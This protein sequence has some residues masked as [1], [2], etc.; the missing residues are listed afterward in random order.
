M[1]YKHLI[2]I[3][4]SI[5]LTDIAKVIGIYIVRLGNEIFTRKEE[6]TIIHPLSLVRKDFIVCKFKVVLGGIPQDQSLDYHVI[7]KTDHSEEPPW[8]TSHL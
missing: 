6:Q 2:N 3:Y 7:W 1:K 8:T 4:Y 5:R